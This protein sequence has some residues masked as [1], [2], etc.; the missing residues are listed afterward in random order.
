MNSKHKF[1]K[2]DDWAKDLIV[3]PLSKEPLILSDR[4][5]KLLSSYGAV[6]PVVGGICDLR[7]L[8]SEMTSDSKVWKKGQEEI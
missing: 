2:L 1:A 4:K 7:L 3:D 6:Y 5:D 8:E